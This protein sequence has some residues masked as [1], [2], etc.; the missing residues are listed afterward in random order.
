MDTDW[1]QFGYRSNTVISS[2]I[3]ICI[4]V[5]INEVPYIRWHIFLIKKTIKNVLQYK[6]VNFT[7]TVDTWIQNVKWLDLQ[8][9]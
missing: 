2:V 1:I 3:S 7:D 8:G 5:S 4:H 9:F 6:S